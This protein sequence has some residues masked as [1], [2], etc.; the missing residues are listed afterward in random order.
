MKYLHDTS[1]KE[2]RQIACQN[3]PDALSLI[4]PFSIKQDIY[5]KKPFDLKI[6]AANQKY[7]FPVDV[8][9]GNLHY[10]ANC[11]RIYHIFTQNGK[12]LTPIMNSP[13][14]SQRY[15][16]ESFRE[17]FERFQIVINAKCTSETKALWKKLKICLDDLED[18]KDLDLSTTLFQINEQVVNLQ[19]TLF[20]ANVPFFPPKIVTTIIGKVNEPI[21]HKTSPILFNSYFNNLTDISKN[22]RSQLFTEIK[23]RYSLDYVP[24]NTKGSLDYPHFLE[25]V[26]ELTSLI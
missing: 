8:K 18:N 17:Q 16:Q 22:H 2:I 7:I 11:N 15:V 1:W 26:S 19:P 21:I 20:D 10:N 24:I 25:T 12:E 4:Q 9:V 23:N 3:N 6:N 13:F 5:I 14:N